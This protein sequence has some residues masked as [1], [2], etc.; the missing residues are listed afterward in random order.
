MNPFHFLLQTRRSGQ[1]SKAAKPAKFRV[2]G[3]LGELFLGP[4]RPTDGRIR[5]W[6]GKKLQKRDDRLCPSNCENLTPAPALSPHFA[7]LSPLSTF[8][9]IWLLTRR[10]GT[11]L[12]PHSARKEVG[13]E[14]AETENPSRKT[15]GG[16]EA[17]RRDPRTFLPDSPLPDRVSAPP[18][19]RRNRPHRRRRGKTA[20]LTAPA[21]KRS[22]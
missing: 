7:P 8:L 3:K 4:H 17:D 12:R 13:E 5:S 1:T 15:T 19:R 9:P 14:R 21:V 10:R 20:A 11:A 18:I 2:C 22:Q 16:E 6:W